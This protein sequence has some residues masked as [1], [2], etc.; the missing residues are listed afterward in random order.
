MAEAIAAAQDADAVVYV[1]GDVYDQVGE[2]TDRADLTLS[3]KQ[4]ELYEK[5]KALGKPVCAVLVASKPLCMGSIPETADAL[6]IAFNGGMYGG[7]AVAKAVF[8]DINPCGKLP[9][10]FPRHSGQLPVYYNALPG[11]H[12]GKYCD[13]DATPLFA[14]GEGISYTTFEVCDLTFDDKALTASV[15]VRNPGAQDGFTVVQ[16]YFNDVVSSVI[17]P[18]KQL[19]G[20]ERVTLRA[21]EE[22]RVTFTFKKEDFALVTPDERY[23]TEPGA[24]DMMVGL[25]SKDEDLLKTTFRI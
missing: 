11:W 8:G 7:E 5:I 3:G 22:K 17:T 24:F 19:C 4:I 20:F 1:V 10:T 25:S 13:Q 15:T 18:V 23:V 21:G 9:I 12:G 2:F 16:A 6:L 14:F